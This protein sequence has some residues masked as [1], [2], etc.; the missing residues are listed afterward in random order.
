MTTIPELKFRKRRQYRYVEVRI[1]TQNG[2]QWVNTGQETLEKA[3]EACDAA[4]VAKLQL[5]ASI[6]VL[7]SD[8]INRLTLRSDLTFSQAIDLW[9]AD[10]RGILAPITVHDWPIH[11]RACFKALGLL[12]QAFIT[13]DRERLSEWVNLGSR[14]SRENKL[15][16][17]KVFFKWAY[18]RALCLGNPASLVRI[19]I[20]DMRVQDLEG[21]VKHPFTYEEYQLLMK[22]DN[23][24]VSPYRRGGRRRLHRPLR[25]QEIAFWRIV[26]CL[27]YW[28]GLRQRDVVS[29]QWESIKEDRIVI[30]QQKTGRRVE[31]LFSDEAICPREL[32]EA[33]KAIPPS[34]GSPYCFPDE[35]AAASSPKNRKRFGNKLRAILRHH[36][37]YK[38][39][40]GFHAL[41]HGCAMRLKGLG[42]SREE[43]AAVLGHAQA[44]SAETYVPLPPLPSAIV[45][46]A[47]R[48]VLTP[49]EMAC[50]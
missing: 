13:P 39:G 31:L 14:A 44:R 23:L 30:Y 9:V 45:V 41:R 2:L 36:G 15:G 28:T 34:L 33:L 11:L 17:L 16:C 27:G 6:N 38:E 25:E 48:S 10:H 4:A 43:I 20:R 1:Q 26:I 22:S 37:L 12:N 7:T 8:V 18:A 5:A 42:R 46:N 24:L 29:L 47:P 40:R 3:Q 32:Q 50:V 19:N 21:R 35:Y 49:E